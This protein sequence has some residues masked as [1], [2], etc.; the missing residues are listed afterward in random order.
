MGNKKVVLEEDE[1]GD[2]AKQADDFQKKL[3]IPLLDKLLELGIDEILV[4][5]KAIEYKRHCVLAEYTDVD[6]MTK[7]W[8]WFPLSALSKV[9]S[10]VEPPAISFLP[11]TVSKKF[12]NTL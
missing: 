8:L 1:E 4:Q 5:I 6:T 11:Q 2:D 3:G 9:N 7:H 10:Q 12:R